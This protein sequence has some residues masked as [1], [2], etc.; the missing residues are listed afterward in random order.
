MK[1]QCL[2]R[3]EFNRIMLVMVA[4]IDKEF[5][6]SQADA[7]FTLL[8]DLPAEALQVAVMPTCRATSSR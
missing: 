5:P 1:N 4:A 8:N 6:E 7:Y 3:H 2:N